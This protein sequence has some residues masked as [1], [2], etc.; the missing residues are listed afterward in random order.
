MALGQ[1][2]HALSCHTVQLTSAEAIAAS[3]DEGYEG[4]SPK[5]C[6]VGG[7]ENNGRVSQPILERVSVS[8]EKL[9]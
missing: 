5:S 2:T 3:L 7:P 1:P 9:A 6:N 8:P 4:V